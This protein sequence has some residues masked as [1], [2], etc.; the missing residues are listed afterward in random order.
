MKSFL[1]RCLGAS[2]ADASNATTQP[3]PALTHEQQPN[4]EDGAGATLRRRENLRGYRYMEFFLVGSVP[5]DGQIKG[6]VYNT[7]EQNTPQGGRD[8]CPQSLVEKLNPAELA[9]EY[10]VPR[11]VLNPP[12]QWLLDWIEI[13]IGAVRDFGGIKAAWCGV[14]NMPKHPKLPPYTV[15]TIE[16]K[17]QFG[18]NKGQT[19]YLLDD[20][21]GNTWIAKS[22]TQ[23]VNP[24]N[25]YANLGTLGSR[26]KLPTGWK[27]RTTVL[28][29]DLILLP[30][31]GVA[32]VLRDDLE[33]VYDVTG[34]GYSNFKP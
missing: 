10:H 14:L 24:E 8:S 33:N 31:S 23:A 15:A 20:P 2:F 30:E 5:V 6:T 1:Y 32:R 27:F 19:E 4:P 9:K 18:F 29:Q 11:V 3:T 28:E 22:F 16:R 7:T 25:T 12:R 17:S 13:P 34:Q 26:L 21:Q